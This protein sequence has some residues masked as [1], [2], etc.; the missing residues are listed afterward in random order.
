MAITCKPCEAVLGAEV[1]GVDLRQVPDAQ[2]IE[3]IED[4]LEH[5]GV[6][7]FHAQHITPE[8]QVAWSRAFG[9]L[10]LTQGV[11]ARL[12]QCPEICVIGNTIDPPVTFSPRTAHDELEWHTDHIHLEVP[13][14]A[15]LLYARAVPS[16]G[17]DTLF[18]C[19]YTAYDTLLPDQQAV[20]DELQVMHSVS[21]LRAYLQ[22]QG[23]TETSTQHDATPAVAVE[24]PLV[25]RHPRSG[26]KA[27]A[28]GNQVSIGI[29]GWAAE[30]A[31]A[32]IRALTGHACQPS[33][34]YRHTWRVQ[35]AVL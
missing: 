8:E 20:Y 7:I 5:Y 4:V 32:F 21:G 28:F 10:T 15:S 9:P 30:Q 18:A 14:R 1:A 34:Q 16:Q 6:L 29:S 26:R 27:L 35:D 19:M 2:T 12:P 23:P 31:C 3:A 13:A 33:Y 17:G 11:E 22:D 25:R 24:C